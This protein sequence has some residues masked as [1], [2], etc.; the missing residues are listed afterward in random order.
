MF[1]RMPYVSWILNGIE[2]FL[3]KG[4][5]VKGT[6]VKFTAK[7]GVQDRTAVRNC[8]DKFCES[9]NKFSD[10][11]WTSMMVSSALTNSNDY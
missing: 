8:N 4:I 9:L 5:F 10:I 3:I 7:Q 2:I 6:S 11:E 1:S